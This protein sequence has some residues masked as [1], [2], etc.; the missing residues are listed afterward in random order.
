M[1][2]CIEERRSHGL[3]L[4]DGPQPTQRVVPGLLGLPNELLAAIWS[5]IPRLDIESMSLVSW[6]IY[7][8]G[9]KF[10]ERH[11]RLKKR[12]RRGKNRQD[13]LSCKLCDDYRICVLQQHDC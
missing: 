5:Y 9:E 8:V 3:A 1:Q 2:L 11:R 13:I 12:Y 10:I 6:R 7:R 4:R